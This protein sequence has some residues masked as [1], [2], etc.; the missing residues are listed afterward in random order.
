[1]LVLSRKRNEQI[2]IAENVVIT[3]V[4]IR[5]DKVRLG[6]EAPKD[7]PVHRKEVYEAIQAGTSCRRRTRHLQG[8]NR[9]HSNG[10]LCQVL[11]FWTE[12]A[13]VWRSWFPVSR[14]LP[15][16]RLRFAWESG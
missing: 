12:S 8:K 13:I 5:G 3:V 6:I 7:V 1:M 9:Q 15:D 11:S 4:D 16:R 2:V 10:Q 14:G